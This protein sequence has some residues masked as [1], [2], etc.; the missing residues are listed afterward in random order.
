MNVDQTCSIL[1]F[2]MQFAPQITQILI[3]FP[4]P[5]HEPLFMF[6]GDLE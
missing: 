6:I 2:P 1:V 5:C 3:F 4:A